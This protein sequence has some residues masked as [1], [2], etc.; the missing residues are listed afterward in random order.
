MAREAPDV[1]PFGR[2]AALAVSFRPVTLRPCLSAGLPLSR[3]RI[4]SVLLSAVGAAACCLCILSSE[5]IAS[6]S[7]A[8]RGTRSCTTVRGLRCSARRCRVKLAMLTAPVASCFNR[9]RRRAGRPRA[10]RQV[11]GVV[12]SSRVVASG[13]SSVVELLPSKQAVASSNLVPRSRF[14]SR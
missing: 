3:P 8:A 2:P 5:D 6:V 13:G 14:H 7:E 11:P 12:R 4:L 9:N 1:R 10:M